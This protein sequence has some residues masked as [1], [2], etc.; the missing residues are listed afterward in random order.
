MVQYH[1]WANNPHPAKRDRSPCFAK[2]MLDQGSIA[3]MVETA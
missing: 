3:H 1:A 2:L